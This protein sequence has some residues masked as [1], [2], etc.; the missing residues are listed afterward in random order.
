M[1]LS[2]LITQCL[3]RDFVEPI[4]PY[5]PLPNRLHVGPA[6]ALRLLGP[7]P[8]VG[9]VAQLMASVRALPEQ[10]IEVVHIRD[11]HDPEDPRQ[12]DHLASFGAHCVRDSEG[13]RLVLE[14]DRQISSHGRVGARGHH[15]GLPSGQPRRHARGGDRL[16]PPRPRPARPG[17]DGPGALR[18]H[19]RQPRRLSLRYPAGAVGLPASFQPLNPTFSTLTLVYPA[20]TARSAAAWEA[21]QS[22]LLQ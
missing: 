22:L 16:R 19:V 17:D 4:Q 15:R 11:W 3:Q 12:Q 1:A 7:D 10:D 9:P 18:D 14:L 6:E 8:S 2:V 21:I 20:S 5:E 13:A